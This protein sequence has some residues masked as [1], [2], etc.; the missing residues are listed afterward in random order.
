ML[1]LYPYVS[2]TSALE[3]LT[4]PKSHTRT[5][6]T[7]KYRTWKQSGPD[8]YLNTE[9]WIRGELSNA[10]PDPVRPSRRR[11]EWWQL[12]KSLANRRHKLPQNVF[13]LNAAFFLVASAWKCDDVLHN[14]SFSD[15]MPRELVFGDLQ[16]KEILK[17]VCYSSWN[18]FVKAYYPLSPLY[19][20]AFC[21]SLY[22]YVSQMFKLAS[23]T[24]HQSALFEFKPFYLSDRQL[25]TLLSL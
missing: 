16:K 6:K 11:P 12:Q 7:R 24:C 14:P 4:G 9:T 3:V 5:K 19:I 21:Y 13:Y 17:I 22:N 8:R 18:G 15:P 1:C 2:T 25:D 20:Q 23:L 10:G